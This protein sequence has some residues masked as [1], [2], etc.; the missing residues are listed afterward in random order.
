[1]TAYVQAIKGRFT[2]VN[3]FSAAVG[4]EKLGREVVPFEADELDSLPLDS[5]TMVCGFVGIVLRAFDR[6]GVRRPEFPS[7][8]SSLEPWFGRRVFTSTLGEVRADRETRFVKPL[9]EQKAFGGFVRRN[10]HDELGRTAHLDD[11][12]P[13]LASDVVHFRAEWRCFVLRGEVIDARRYVGDF[14]APSP[15]WTV[16]DACIGALADDAPVGYAIDLGITDDGRTLVVELNDGY[17]L[18]TYGTDPTPYARLLEA[19][20]EQICGIDAPGVGEPR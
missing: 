20:W 6:L 12:F 5:G 17:S 15:D 9:L 11:A 18:G 8:P 16:L 10:P 19:R 14:R 13:I 7:L 3:T 1:M 4:F 2:N